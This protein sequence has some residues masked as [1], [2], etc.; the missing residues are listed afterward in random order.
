MT[1]D[2]SKLPRHMLKYKTSGLAVCPTPVPITAEDWVGMFRA[3]DI[4]VDLYCASS[5]MG[6]SDALE[7]LNEKLTKSAASFPDALTCMER[8]RARNEVPLSV[9]MSLLKERK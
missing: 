6:R 4:H 5:N 3:F 1:V 8:E 2:L 9:Q 7:A